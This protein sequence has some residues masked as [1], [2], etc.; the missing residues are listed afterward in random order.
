LHFRSRPHAVCNEGTAGHAADTRIVPRRC[1][2]RLYFVV[3]T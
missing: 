3:L 1:V 2:A